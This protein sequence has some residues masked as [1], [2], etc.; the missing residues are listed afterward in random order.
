MSYKLAE[1]LHI[2]DGEEVYKQDR[3][4]SQRDGKASDRKISKRIPL[5]QAFP[6]ASAMQ[7]Y[8]KALK[9]VPA[10]FFMTTGSAYT[11]VIPKR[12]FRVCKEVTLE[13]S[14]E[15]KGAAARLAPTNNWFSRI[16][17]KQ[18]SEVL[19]SIY[20]DYL[21]IG[22]SLM[23]RH[24]LESVNKG[25]GIN[26]DLVP[27][28][29][30]PAGT[31]KNFYL[32][33]IGTSFNRPIVWSNLKSD[34]TFD[35][36][37]SGNPVAS[38]AG[39]VSVTGMRF[40]VETEN[41]GDNLDSIYNNVF[42]SELRAHSFIE[43]VVQNFP[44]ITMTPSTTSEFVMSS[45][46]SKQNAALVVAIRP[47]NSSNTSNGRQNY[48]C[49]GP[50]ATID[51]KDSGGRTLFSGGNAVTEE[52]LRT[53]VI[54]GHLDND[55]FVN[56]RL[57]LLPL[58]RD[59]KSSVYGGVRD[60]FLDLSSATDKL[61]LIPDAAEVKEV[62]TLTLSAVLTAGNYTLGFMGDYTPPLI[63]SSTDAQIKAA[64][65]NLDVFKYA[66]AGPVTVTVVGTL[67]ATGVTFTF[68]NLANSYPDNDD[69][70]VLLYQTGGKTWTVNIT[71][72]GQRGFIGGTYDVSITALKFKEMSLLDGVFKSADYS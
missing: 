17:I 67:E 53:H 8:T 25:L 24:K 44:S 65:E 23:D 50:K 43:G 66:P 71:T 47:Q 45:L 59:L 28:K 51:I 36:Y 12:A 7:I 2:G 69:P 9:Q 33:F 48:V 21:Q 20:P 52:Y 34:L 39:T 62:H 30:M 57:Y 37:S 4:V 13:I 40:I 3:V 54:G 41:I 14:V 15:I 55:W 72:Q 11:D 6:S 31:K 1:K 35:F 70:L 10:D 60:G 19:T 68:D 26:K 46:T 32:P 56:K 64:V 49:L 61:V 29:S 63:F 27:L 16:E 18:D 38:G 22:L 42:K 58:C 5:S